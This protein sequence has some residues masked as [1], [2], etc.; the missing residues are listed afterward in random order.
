VGIRKTS[1]TVLDLYEF[2][3]S[4]AYLTPGRHIG[5]VC[6]VG[7]SPPCAHG[8]QAHL[9]AALA[10][11]R[12]RPAAAKTDAA[13]RL[14]RNAARVRFSRARL[15]AAHWGDFG[16]AAGGSRGSG[17]TPAPFLP[18]GNGDPLANHRGYKVRV[19]PRFG[20]SSSCSLHLPLPS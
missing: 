11:S 13:V 1:W 2:Y 8:L 10:R 4:H 18:R 20:S 3:N 16:A 12:A 7:P 9:F 6:E 15:R 17:K 14:G 5:R 19:A